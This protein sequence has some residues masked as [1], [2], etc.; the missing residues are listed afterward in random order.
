MSYRADL[1]ALA[2]LVERI[3]R[4][5]GRARDLADQLA[6]E[7][8]VLA[9]HWSG[10]AADGAAAAHRRWAGGDAQVRAALDSLAGFVHTAH[11]NYRSAAEANTA[12]WR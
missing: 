9:V 8:K 11:A 6:R 10:A 1:E 2:G 12:M 5:D 4:F 3:R 7:Q